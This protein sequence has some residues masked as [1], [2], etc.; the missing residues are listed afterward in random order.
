L[1]ARLVASGQLTPARRAAIAAEPIAVRAASGPRVFAAP[2]F[3]DWVLG[4]VPAPQRRAGGTLFTTLDLELQEQLETAAREHVARNAHAGVT[5]AGLVVLDAASGEVRAMVGSTGYDGAQL[6]IVTRR[7]HLGSLLKP[8]AYALAIESGA[9]PASIAL[10]VGDVPSEYR[11]RD[12]VGREAGPLSYREAVGGSYN[13]AAVHVLERVGVA[14]LHARLRRAGVAELA[15]PPD[16]YGLQLALGAARARLLDVAAGYGFLVRGGAVRAPCGVRALERQSRGGDG[17]SAHG[18]RP[19]EAGDARVFSR[20]VSW[21]VMDMLADPA[22]RHRRFGRDLPLDGPGA[23]AAKTGTAS[24]LSD[25]AAVLASSQLIVGAWAGRFDGAPAHGT[26]GMWGAAPLARRALEIALRGREPELPPRPRELVA[27]DVCALSGEPAGPG[28]PLAHGY[29]A[30]P[31]R[32]RCRRHDRAGAELDPPV[33]LDGWAARARAF[34][35][36]TA[37]APR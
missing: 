3:V 28:C 19:G 1:L 37:H 32:D 35:A 36:R 8:F 9:S 16:R 5:E 13:L 26:S 6:N 33:E 31:A 11:S 4:T 14:A 12:W 17:S 29:A 34:A 7:R 24:G 15:L 25:V 30:A 22:A 21:L 10:D 2:H 20:A 27:I 18:W 23:V